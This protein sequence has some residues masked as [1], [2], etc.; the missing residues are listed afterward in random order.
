MG[1]APS[2]WEFCLELFDG[3]EVPVPIFSQPRSR[4]QG[5]R[6][7]SFTNSQRDHSRR[8]CRL[9][10]VSRISRRRPAVFQNEGQSFLAEGL[11]FTVA[12]GKRSAALGLVDESSR[13]AEGHVHM[14]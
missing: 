3:G 4:T 2:K 12:W 14:S 13:L 1:L 8:S 6:D 11:V 5:L 9:A 10:V 7:G